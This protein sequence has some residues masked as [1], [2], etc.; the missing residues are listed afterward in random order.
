MDKKETKLTI[1]EKTKT[2]EI[3]KSSNSS[4]IRH[5]NPIM[6][7]ALE[8]HKEKVGKFSVKDLFRQ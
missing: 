2:E 7:K 6:K 4:A 8:F 5:T 1:I 3:E